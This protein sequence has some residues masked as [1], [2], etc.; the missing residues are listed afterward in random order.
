MHKRASCPV[1]VGTVQLGGG[2]PVAIQSMTNTDTRDVDATVAQI[3]RLEAAGC[4]IVRAAV[5]DEDCARALGAIRRRIHIPLVADVHFS[6]KLAI[7][8]IKNGADKLRIN[9]GNIGSEA[10]VAEVV[11]AAKDH[12]TPIRVGVNSGSLEKQLLN[13]YGG[14]TPE[15]LAESALGEVALL[16]RLGFSNIVIAIKASTVTDNVAANRIA[17][18]RVNYPFHLGVTEAGTAYEGALRS[19]VG[20]GTLLMEG[21]GDT[22]RVSLSGDPAPEVEAAR[23]ILQAAGLRGGV[24][25]VSCPTCGRCGIDVAGIA[26]E[27]TAAL[28]A[29]DSDLKVAVMGCVVN[30]PGEARECDVGIAGGKEYG[31]LIE[32]GKPPVK[33][34]AGQLRD[35]LIQ[36]VHELAQK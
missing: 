9:P 22:I 16:E 35:A 32:R 3:L 28:R 12:G 36:R 7:A 24:H 4:E 13:R 23:I 18:A 10:R 15:A 8:A 30:G 2:A 17:A 25:V 5:F 31:L 20:I 26:Q 21:I 1:Q 6:S 11:A 27:V 14:P 34:P 29:L 33:L 19:A